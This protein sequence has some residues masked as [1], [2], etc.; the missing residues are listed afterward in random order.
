MRLKGKGLPKKLGD[1]GSLTVEILIVV[2]TDPSE[3]ERELL[4]QWQQASAF[5]PRRR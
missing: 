5:D 1:R 3:K 2:P 4:Q